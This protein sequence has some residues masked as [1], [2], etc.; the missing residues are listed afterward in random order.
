MDFLEA[1]RMAYRSVRAN[2]TRSLITLMII[3]LGITALVGILTAIDT[4]IFSLTDS[5]SSLGANSFTIVRSGNSMSGNKD[6]KQQK[7]G[8][9]ISLDQ[10]LQFKERYDYSGSKVTISTR[11][12]GSATLKYQDKKSNPNVRIYG[13]DENQFDVWDYEIDYGRNFHFQN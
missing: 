4:L 6:G 3:A 8:D 5:I 7:R 11:P 1:V 10:A 13:I 9:V 2:L 12:T